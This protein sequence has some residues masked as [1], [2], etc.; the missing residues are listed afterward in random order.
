MG[1]LPF[2]IFLGIVQI[3]VRKSGISGHPIKVYDAVGRLEIQAAVAESV[4]IGILIGWFLDRL[5]DCVSV[6]HQSVIQFYVGH[7]LML[8]KQTGH[9]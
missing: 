1:Y 6:L 8:T 2:T 3:K 9:R 5:Y 4:Q 7:H